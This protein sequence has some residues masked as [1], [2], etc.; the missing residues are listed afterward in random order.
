MQVSNVRLKELIERFSSCFS[1]GFDVNSQKSSQDLVMALQEL[2]ELRI[3]NDELQHD[4][5][6]LNGTL[7]AA[8][9]I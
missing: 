3:K 8:Q 5:S 1:L 4:L 9:R 7:D 6:V 2:A